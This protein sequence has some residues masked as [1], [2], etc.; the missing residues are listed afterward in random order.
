MS[1]P[2]PPHLPPALQIVGLKIWVHGYQFPEAQDVYDGN[3]LRVTVNCVSAG[4]RVWVSGALLDTVAFE[5][6][7]LGLQSLY[8]TLQGEAV[9]ES[10]ETGVVVRL[11]AIDRV[12]H[13]QMRVELTSQPYGGLSHQSHRMDFEVDQSYLPPVIEQ[14][15]VLLAKYPIRGRF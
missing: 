9:L 6:F 12:G 7:R 4:A 8:E 2:I 13:L 5:N 3:W 14:C 1:F 11:V 15:R 10:W